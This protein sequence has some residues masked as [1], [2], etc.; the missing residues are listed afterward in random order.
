MRGMESAATESTGQR[1]GDKRTNGLTESRLE[2]VKS[3]TEVRATGVVMNDLISLV[4]SSL[5]TLLMPSHPFLFL[6]MPSHPFCSLLSPMWHR[7]L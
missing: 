5:L 7:E 6:L 2:S 4:H 3:R 1:R